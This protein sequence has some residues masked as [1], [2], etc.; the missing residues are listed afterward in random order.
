MYSEIF[1]YKNKGEYYDWENEFQELF[2]KRCEVFY[3]IFLRISEE[4]H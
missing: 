3:I 4:N 2:E 1:T